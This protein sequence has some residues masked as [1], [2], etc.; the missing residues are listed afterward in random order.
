MVCGALQLQVLLDSQSC[1]RNQRNVGLEYLSSRCD[2]CT[3][4]WKA[5]IC[6]I[7]C[8]SCYRWLLRVVLYAAYLL[9]MKYSVS[10]H[11][12]TL[13][14]P[15]LCIHRRSKLSGMMWLLTCSC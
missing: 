8:S 1:A 14:L 10:C 2:N 11:W 5:C 9:K 4:N 15:Y 6:D 13:Y 3:P 7:F 12:S